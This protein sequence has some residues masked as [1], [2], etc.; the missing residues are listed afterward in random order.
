[1][2]LQIWL[3]NDITGKG[4]WRDFH[5]DIDKI[6]G[7]YMPDDE[8]EMEGNAITICYYGGFI[9]IKEDPAILKELKNRFGH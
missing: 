7:Y 4:E 9:S 5:F 1:M 3:F 6:D 2:N 8:P